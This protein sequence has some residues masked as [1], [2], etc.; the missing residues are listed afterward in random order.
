MLLTRFIWNQVLW[1]AADYRCVVTGSHL[2]SYFMKMLGMQSCIINNLM[3]WGGKIYQVCHQ[4]IWFATFWCSVHLCMENNPF[5]YRKRH[6]VCLLK[7]WQRLHNRLRQKP[8]K[9]VGSEWK[10]KP[11][12]CTATC[13][14]EKTKE[15]CVSAQKMP[16]NVVISYCFHMCC[17]SQ[18]LRMTRWQQ[19]KHACFHNGICSVLH[20]E[21]KRRGQVQGFGLEQ[22]SGL[23]NSLQSPVKS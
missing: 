19:T 6:Q 20:R 9:H 13:L 7:A 14:A 23:F 8:L 17:S 5:I 1:S 12:F 3:H 22:R 21:R 10:F 15:D 2:S 4:C 18:V 16:L 11:F